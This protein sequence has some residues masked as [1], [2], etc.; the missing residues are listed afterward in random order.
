MESRAAETAAQRD[1]H[2]PDITEESNI[3]TLPLRKAPPPIPS[4]PQAPTAQ[5]Q[6]FLAELGFGELLED[7][8]VSC[9]YDPATRTTE[10]SIEISHNNLDY[11]EFIM[12]FYFASSEISAFAGEANHTSRRDKYGKLS[13]LSSWRTPGGVYQIIGWRSE[14]QSYFAVI[15]TEAH[16]H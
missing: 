10:F 6:A 8:F 16:R 14:L 7:H 15:F 11:E 5:A 1:L 9:S 13:C 2:M 3:I 4:W 12:T